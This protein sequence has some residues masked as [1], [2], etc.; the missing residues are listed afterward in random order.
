MPEEM[1]ASRRGSGDANQNLARSAISTVVCSDARAVRR[2]GVV[3]VEPRR[4]AAAGVA[5]LGGPEMSEE[6]GQY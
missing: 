2:D 1:G 3:L 4:R 5:W 6:G